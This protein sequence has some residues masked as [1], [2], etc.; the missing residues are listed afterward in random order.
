MTNFTTVS[1]LEIPKSFKSELLFGCYEKKVSKEHSEQY[2]GKAFDYI[3]SSNQIFGIS[4]ESTGQNFKKFHYTF[5]LRTC[6]P[7]DEGHIIPGIFPG[8]EILIKA[9]GSTQ[10]LNLKNTLSEMNKNGINLTEMNQKNYKFIGE[11]LQ[12]K[13]KR[14]FFLNELI[15]DQKMS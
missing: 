2:V 4:Y 14:S 9:V 15:Y 10:S 7:G 12:A 3:F 8:A 6:V 13:L 5:V 1:T 11:I